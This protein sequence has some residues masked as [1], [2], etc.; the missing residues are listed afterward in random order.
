LFYEG[1]RSLLKGKIMPNNDL[2]E[3]KYIEEQLEA[4]DGER[5]AIQEQY[6]AGNISE[7]DYKVLLAKNEY[8]AAQI[9][10]RNQESQ[11]KSREH[12][13]ERKRDLF[14]D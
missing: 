2:N 7:K 9:K 6:D 10:E 12:V 4:L 8:L 11:D 13:H 3:E 5:S 14:N 1:G